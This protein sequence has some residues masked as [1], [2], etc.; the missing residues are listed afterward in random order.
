M[1]GGNWRNAFAIA[2]CTSC[3]AESMSRL[4]E[5]W[6]VIDALPCELTDDME[7][8]PAI[9]ENCFSRGVATDDAMVLGLA[10][11]KLAET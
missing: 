1:F 9:V 4:N 3:A 6:I 11:G 5:N 7:S 8:T 10:P 2:A